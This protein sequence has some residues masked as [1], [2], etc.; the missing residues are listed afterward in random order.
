MSARVASNY[1]SR[2]LL[3]TGNDIVD[4]K[5]DAWVDGQRQIDLSIKYQ[6][7]KSIRL[8]FDGLNLNKE[9]YYVYQGVNAYNFQNEQYGRS[10]IVSLN[11]TQ[12]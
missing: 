6:I 12:F 5:L 11:M 1:K 7:S 10:F 4:S 8:S 3:Q 2:Y 9:K